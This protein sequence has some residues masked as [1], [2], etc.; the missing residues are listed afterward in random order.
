MFTELHEE[1]GGVGVGGRGVG[2]GVGAAH[3][4]V[5]GLILFAFGTQTV[6]S[7]QID[8]Q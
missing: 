5:G 8:K 4:G 7:M 1:N 6:Q 3:V 2:G